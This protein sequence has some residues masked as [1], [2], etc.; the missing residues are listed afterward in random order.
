M[1]EQTST[2]PFVC[3]KCRGEL[4]TDGRAA[5][6]PSRHSYDRSRYGYYN[7][8]L[9]AVGGTHG[10]NKE[11]VLA[12]R[13]FL[14]EG[15]YLPLVRRI[16]ELTL[17]NTREGGAVLDAGCGEGYYTD[18]VERALF[19]RDNSTRVLAFDISKDAV[20]EVTRKNSRISTAVA[21]SYSMPV[22]DGSVSTVINTFS[23][24]AR[25]EIYRALGRGGT[26][27]MAIP[28]RDHLYELKEQLY[29]TPYRNEVKDSAL[30]GFTLIHDERLT[31][32]MSLDSKDSILSLF[33]MTPYAY[34]TPRESAERLLSLPKLKCTADFH[35]FVYRK[36]S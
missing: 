34:R 18:A 21:G 3:P 2:L 31:F 16:C 33:K 11:M 9:T 25:E 7:L 28:E 1:T 4:T 15:H 17:D 12:R 35:I 13:A 24:F 22:A 19:D 29:K 14:G 5:V 10:D 20:R 23:P 36:D 6:C 32:T 26:L 8:L 30:E 27:I